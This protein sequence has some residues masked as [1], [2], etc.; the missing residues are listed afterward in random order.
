MTTS[1]IVRPDNQIRRRAGRSRMRWFSEFRQSF[2]LQ[3]PCTLH[4]TQM[5]KHNYTESFAARSHNT[6][7]H[8]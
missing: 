5:H 2:K 4:D 1:S 6:T 8:D 3:T 7:T